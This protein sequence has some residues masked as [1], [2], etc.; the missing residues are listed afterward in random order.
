[1]RGWYIGIRYLP[2][3]FHKQNM[4]TKSYSMSFHCL[5]SLSSVRVYTARGI[6][7]NGVGKKQG[8]ATAKDEHSTSTIKLVSHWIVQVQSETTSTNSKQQQPYQIIAKKNFVK[9]LRNIQKQSLA[10]FQSST[11]ATVKSPFMRSPFCCNW[12]S[13]YVTRDINCVSHCSC[14]YNCLWQNLSLLWRLP[15]ECLS[16]KKNSHSRDMFCVSRR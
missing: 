14:M 2:Y 10:Y 11:T 7:S 8:F 13:N 15:S 4:K 5:P 3:L 12:L 1:M 16:L 6:C 9:K